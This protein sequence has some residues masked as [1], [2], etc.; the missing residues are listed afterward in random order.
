MIFCTSYQFWRN[1]ET[2]TFA[3]LHKG[4]ER[5]VCHRCGSVFATPNP[6]KLHLFFNCSAVNLTSLWR[7]V[8]QI[9]TAGNQQHPAT[10]GTSIFI[11]SN[12][13]FSHLHHFHHHPSVALPSPV[14][15]ATPVTFTTPAHVE[16]LVG[17]LA[18]SKH[19]HVC[20]YCGKVYS[21]KYGLKIHIRWSY[22]SIT[23]PFL[24]NF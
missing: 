18:R 11:R 17:H 9:L 5:Y 6:L 19:G 14:G 15:A 23:C 8:G 16:S 4:G 2:N 20:I 24:F 3:H 13:I 12:G 22:V 7:R 10:D 21:R 1:D